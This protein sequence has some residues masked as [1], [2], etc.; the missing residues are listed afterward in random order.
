MNKY[1]PEFD[2]LVYTTPPVRVDN[3]SIPNLLVFSVTDKDT[4]SF[5]V[6]QFTISVNDSNFYVRNDSLTNTFIFGLNGQL[7]YNINGAHRYVVE[8]TATDKG[9][10]PR[11]SKALIIVPLINYN[12]YPP[13]YT[14]PVLITAAITLNSGSQLA[15]LNAWDIDGDNVYCSLDSSSRFNCLLGPFIHF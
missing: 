8:V 2:Q 14:S 10:P 9:L 15:I 1:D 7:F 6:A 4:R 3:T 5:D 13:Q 11:S 12:M